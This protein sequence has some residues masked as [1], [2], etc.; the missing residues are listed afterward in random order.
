MRDRQDETL[1]PDHAVV[2]HGDWR[3]NGWYYWSA[4]YPDEGSVGPF[5]T[6]LAAL[7]HARAAGFEVPPAGTALSDAQRD[8]IARIKGG[9]DQIPAGR[10]TRSEA[11]RGVVAR[12]VQ[13][14]LDR[15]T[16]EVEALTDIAL[17]YA[18]KFEQVTSGDGSGHADLGHALRREIGAARDTGGSSDA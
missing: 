6:S 10:I 17:R 1:T 15:L 14:E 12:A 16:G 5:T 18:A 11:E 7:R 3:G 4:E 9:S 2:Q 8:L 13:K